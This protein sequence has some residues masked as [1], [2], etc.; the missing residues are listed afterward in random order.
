[1]IV[2]RH[3]EFRQLF[4]LTSLFENDQEDARISQVIWTLMYKWA[5]EDRE[6]KEG[7]AIQVNEEFS[8]VDFE[9]VALVHDRMNNGAPVCNMMHNDRP[10]NDQQILNVTGLA[11][12]EIYD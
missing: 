4:Q 2:I 3:S 6:Y 11:T 9:Y 1:M 12:E 8:A 5:N 7:G 10:E